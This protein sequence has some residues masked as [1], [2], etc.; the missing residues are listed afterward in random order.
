MCIWINKKTQQIDQRQSTALE[1]YKLCDKNMF[2][3]VID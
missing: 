1:S 3:T 2:P